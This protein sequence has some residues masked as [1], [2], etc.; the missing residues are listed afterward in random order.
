MERAWRC[1][2]VSSGSSSSMATSSVACSSMSAR[3][4]ASAGI[5]MADGP[6]MRRAVPPS[7]ISRLTRYS[8][9]KGRI[10]L[11]SA[12]CTSGGMPT[13]WLLSACSS[14]H[15]P[16][17]VL[18]SAT[19]AAEPVTMM[20]GGNSCT[21]NM[22]GATSCA[23]CAR[24]W[25]SDASSSSICGPG[26][27]MATSC[28]LSCARRAWSAMRAEMHPSPRRVTRSRIGSKS[29]VTPN[30]AS[31]RVSSPSS[32]RQSC[33]S[34]VLSSNDSSSSSHWCERDRADS[35]CMAAST[36]FLRP[37][38][39]MDVAIAKKE[40]EQTVSE[41]RLAPGSSIW[42]WCF[43]S[44]SRS[45]SA[46]GP[47]SKSMQ[48][49]GSVIDSAHRLLASSAR[50]M[51]CLAASTAATVPRMRNSSFC[52]SR[53]T[54][55]AAPVSARIRLSS[56][57]PLPRKRNISPASTLTT[58]AASALYCSTASRAA[59]ALSTAALV[60]RTVSVC[61]VLPSAGLFATAMVVPVSRWMDCTVAPPLPSIIPTWYDSISRCS[62][63]L[64]FASTTASNSLTAAS[65]ALRE[66]RTLAPPSVRSMLTPCAAARARS[67]SP[68]PNNAPVTSSGTSTERTLSASSF[69]SRQI[70]VRAASTATYGPLMRTVGSDPLP[71]SSI[72]PPDSLCMRWIVAPPL[73]S[74]VPFCSGSNLIVAST[75]RCVV[76]SS[77]ICAARLATAA[78]S[79]TS[80]TCFSFLRTSIEQP[81]SPCSCSIVAPLRPMSSAT[82]ASSMPMRRTTTGPISAITRE[83][84]STA[85]LSPEILTLFL[86]ARTIT[87]HSVRSFFFHL[88]DDRSSR[89]PSDTGVRAST[90]SSTGTSSSA[91]VSCRDCSSRTVPMSANTAL[92]LSAI[93]GPEDGR[94]HVRQVRGL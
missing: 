69:S 14:S 62:S 25:P 60:P 9:A 53:G 70:S 38:I 34:S 15:V 28:G 43:A 90:T 78:S 77:L 2:K 80:T 18:A 81:L 10:L 21:A 82:C 75:L 37:L 71:I 86:V 93:C 94:G 19:I 40:P 30:S 6:V 51:A 12:G 63:T 72:A 66:P 27:A 4:S 52:W 85:S 87:A 42:T 39:D 22:A 58:S 33:A 67:F 35:S 73:P 68:R 61:V 24:I 74:N 46:L 13:C 54:S 76:K 56:S 41:G 88:A 26:Q 79:P 44:S 48:C 57:P 91:A 8:A 3:T 84:A 55:I 36:C 59:I 1:A 17:L 16:H 89:S 50:A 7:T 49:H 47:R 64:R 83:A 65:T 29:S 23:S 11:A 5:T 32:C 31:R 20:A 45:L 92:R